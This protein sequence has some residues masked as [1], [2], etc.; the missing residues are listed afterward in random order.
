MGAQLRRLGESSVRGGYLMSC[1]PTTRQP[2]GSR[3]HVGADAGDTTLIR[4]APP[5]H[6][7]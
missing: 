5:V 3:S 6:A 4:V 1:T 2:K 7:H